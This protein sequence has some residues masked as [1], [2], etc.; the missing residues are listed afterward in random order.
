[1][2]LVGG[3]GGEQAHGKSLH[4]TEGHTRGGGAGEVGVALD[5]LS[6]AKMAGVLKPKF[7]FL[8]RVDGSCNLFNRWFPRT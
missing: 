7:R 3:K 6:L 2:G 1:M 5:L 4:G 8:D